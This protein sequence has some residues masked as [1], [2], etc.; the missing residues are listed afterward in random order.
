MTGGARS[1]KS[2]FAERLCM[3]RA[4]GA[5]YIATAQAY[6]MEMKER[7]A[8]HRVKRE[9]AGYDWQ[10]LEEAKALPELLRRLGGDQASQPSPAPM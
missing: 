1:G 5:C 10:T 3:S 8:L 6:D 2:G 9:A 7:I 4:P